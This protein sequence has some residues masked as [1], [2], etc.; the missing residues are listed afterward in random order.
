MTNTERPHRLHQCS[1]ECG[2]CRARARLAVIAERKRAG[3]P[4]P[5]TW[6]TPPV[7]GTRIRLQPTPDYGHEDTTVVGFDDEDGAVFTEHG[8][9]VANHLDGYR[10]FEVIR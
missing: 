7:I 4:K 2:Y 10:R 3:Q 9:I 5:A 6:P 8:E 1:A